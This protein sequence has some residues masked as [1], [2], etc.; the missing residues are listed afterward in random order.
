MS[1]KLVDVLDR[2]GNHLH[3]YRVTLPESC[4]DQDDDAF[5]SKALE[6]AAYGRLVSNERLSELTARMHVSRRGALAPYGDEVRADSET[7]TGLEDALRE[8][9][10][11]LWEKN[12]RPE[13][14]ADR[15]WKLAHDETT[16]ERSHVLWEQDGSRPDQADKN[17]HQVE[18]FEKA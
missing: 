6:A 5:Q 10:Y 4:G 11:Y 3:T 17:W 9:A 7:H 14:E 13:G 2:I 15:F 8:R 12:G 18:K 1:E 16:A